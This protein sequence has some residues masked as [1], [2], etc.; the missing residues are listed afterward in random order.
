MLRNLAAGLFILAAN[1]A[2]AHAQTPPQFGLPIDCEIGP[3]CF[4]QKYVDLRKG[5][6][7]ADYRCGS[8]SNDKHTGTDFRLVNHSVMA[9]GVAVLAAADGIVRN[10]RDGMPDVDARLVGRATVLD[11]GLGNTVI[12]D[13]GGG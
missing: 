13:H 12:V 4:I 11:R 8:L 2:T 5:K 9:D 1:F 3:T 7:Y 6:D 10:I